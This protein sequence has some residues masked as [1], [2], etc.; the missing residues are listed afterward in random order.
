MLVLARGK[1]ESVT[2]D[3]DTE[4]KILSIRGNKV[5]LGITAPRSRVVIR[6]ELLGLERMKKAAR[7]SL[8][9]AAG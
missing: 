5:R 6:T 2:I 4:I 1:E 3:E 7:D 9:R 8:V